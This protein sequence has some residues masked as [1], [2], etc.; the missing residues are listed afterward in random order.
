MEVRG[1]IKDHE[2]RQ[3]DKG[4]RGREGVREGERKAWKGEV[5]QDEGKRR[6]NISSLLHY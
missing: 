1:K 2:G 4:K 5:G 6:K 3:R